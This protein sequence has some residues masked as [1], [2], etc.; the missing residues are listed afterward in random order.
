ML[1][2]ERRRIVEA[3]KG[4]SSSYGEDRPLSD[5]VKFTQMVFRFCPLCASAMNPYKEDGFQREKCSVCGWVHYHNSRPTVS[6]IIAKD[7]KVLLCKRAKDPFKGRWDL[8]GGYLEEKESSEDALR[9]EMKE[10]LGIEIQEMKLSSVVGPCFYPFGGQD[11]WNTDIYYVVTTSNVP[12]ATSH[13]DVESVAWFNPD[14][15]PD[16]AFDTNVKAILE[17][18]NQ[19]SNV[20]RH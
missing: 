19:Q 8:P 3:S 12:R 11:Q 5:A 13:S 9:R 20:S 15:L 17:W 2:G 18:E 10:E 16:M 4:R 6:A 1:D 7:G 14:R